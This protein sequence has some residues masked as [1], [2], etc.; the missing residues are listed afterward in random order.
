DKHA[1]LRVRQTRDRPIDSLINCLLSLL[2]GHPVGSRQKNLVE[3]LN[4]FLNVERRHRFARLVR[5]FSELADRKEILETK[6]VQR[7]LEVALNEKQDDPESLTGRIALALF[8]EAF[9]SRQ[10]KSPSS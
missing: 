10:K 3:V 7:K 8:P 5:R 1:F 6:S 9:A 4:T 2:D